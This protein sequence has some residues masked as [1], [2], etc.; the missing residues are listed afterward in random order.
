[1]MMQRAK[2]VFIVFNF[3]LLVNTGILARLCVHAAVPK[4]HPI[5][6]LSMWNSPAFRARCVKL[7]LDNLWQKSQHVEEQSCLPQTAT[8]GEGDEGFSLPPMA[9]PAAQ[10]VS[11]GAGEELFNSNH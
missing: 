9:L 1:M 7:M 11:R 2:M 8:W 3:S 6:L 10:E 5:A 4:P